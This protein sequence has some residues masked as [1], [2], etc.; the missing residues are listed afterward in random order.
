LTFAQHPKAFLILDGQ[1]RVWG[2]SKARTELRVPV[3]IYNRLTRKQE[4][5]L[6][7]DINTKQKPVPNELLLDIKHLADIENDQETR[8]RD[9]FDI[10]NTGNDSILLGLLSPSER[11]KGKLSRVSFNSACNPILPY[12]ENRSAEELFT[13]FK[14]YLTAFAAGLEKVRHRDMLLQ[15]YGFKAIM[16]F[17]PEVAGRVKGRFS[18]EYAVDNFSDVLSDVFANVTKQQILAARNNAR[19]MQEVFSKALV[20]GFRL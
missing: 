20:K 7:I 16:G 19:Q 11:A 5:R 4:T 18:G 15:P 1:H 10:F 6:F 17:F 8:L 12:L 9:I 3:V 2:F 13:I 14:A